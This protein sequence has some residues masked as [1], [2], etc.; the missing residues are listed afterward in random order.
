MKIEDIQKER[1]AERLI[2]ADVCTDSGSHCS[3][4]GQVEIK[5]RESNLWLTAGSQELTPVQCRKLARA[6]QEI[7]EEE[8]AKYSAASGH[9]SDV[10]T[11]RR[12]G[13]ILR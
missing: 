9:Q 2:L 1:E 6:L 5:W 3:G 12:G 4:I 13:E 10:R 7:L 11:G 8:R